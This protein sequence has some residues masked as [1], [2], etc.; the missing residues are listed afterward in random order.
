MRG[1]PASRV[2]KTPGWP[3]VATRVTRL[4]AGLARQPHHQLAALGHAAVLGGDRG[5]PAPTP[6]GAARPRRG[7]SRSRP[8]RR[9]GR[10][11][12]GP[13]GGERAR[14]RW[15]RSHRGNR[16]GSVCVMPGSLLPA[17]S[18]RPITGAIFLRSATSSTNISGVMDCGPS[19][20]ARLGSLWTSMM[21]PSAPT[22]AAARLKGRDLVPP[23]GAVGR[24][25]E[26]REVADLLHR[27]N[28]GE[29]QGVAGEIR[30]ASAP[31]ARRGSPSSSPPRGCT[32]PTSGTPRASRTARASA[33]PASS[34]LPARF[35]SEKF[36][37]LRA[38]IWMTSAYF[39]TRSTLSTSMASVTTGRPVASRA[40]AR[41]LQAGLAQA[42]EGV[43]AG[44]RLER[45]AAEDVGA[46]RLDRARDGQGLLDRSPPRRARP[47]ARAPGRRPPRA[48]TRT[49]VSSLF[50]SRET[51]L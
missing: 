24:V 17:E 23:P 49:M 1:A 8:G 20:S 4:E 41:M 18:L 35:S 37:M 34:R 40:S 39:S 46:R 31:R 45:P 28:D 9:P 7:A 16:V 30:E 12:R 51:S 42:L 47:S 44:A 43:G 21:R 11:R 10:P 14:P 3:S 15:S 26:D 25:H 38:P 33:A 6:A 48:P 32:R 13:C 19:D 22:A 27:G 2:A 50:T 29:V 36:C 5:L